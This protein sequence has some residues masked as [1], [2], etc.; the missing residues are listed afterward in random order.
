V[1]LSCAGVSFDLTESRCS[2][3]VAALRQAQAPSASASSSSSGGSGKLNLTQ[4][5]RTRLWCLLCRYSTMFGPGMIGKMHTKAV[6]IRVRCRCE[7]NENTPAFSPLADCPHGLQ[8]NHIACVR[9][10]VVGHRERVRR[11]ANCNGQAAT[12]RRRSGWKHNAI[13]G[14][15]QC[16]TRN[17][18]LIAR[19]R[20]DFSGFRSRTAKRAVAHTPTPAQSLR[21]RKHTSSR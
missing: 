19:V 1:E 7:R 16:T 6:G 4:N 2:K 21:Q 20:A 13:R 12:T 3:L 9:V 14:H 5:E 17:P 15:T 8:L 10:C 11:H 18:N